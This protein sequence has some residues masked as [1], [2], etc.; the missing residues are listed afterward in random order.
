MLFSKKIALTTIVMAGISIVLF[1]GNSS[2]ELN[3]IF[4]Y[5]LSQSSE[6]LFIDRIKSLILL[7][8]S[9][10][11]LISSLLSLERTFY[12]FQVFDHHIPNVINKNIFVRLFIYFNIIWIKLFYIDN[13]IKKVERLVF[14]FI[15]F[16]LLLI[17]YLYYQYKTCINSLFVS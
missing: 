16:T 8:S 10:Y 13:I 11:F 7:Q 15:S 4:I 2:S 5:F 12:V 14:M 1:T 3:L 9:S 17:F 6:F